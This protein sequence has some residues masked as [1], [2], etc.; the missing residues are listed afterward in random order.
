MTRNG[1]PP[2]MAD[3]AELVGVSHQTASRVVN[4]KGRVSPR[5]PRPGLASCTPLPR[6]GCGHICASYASRCALDGRVRS[7]EA[8]FRI[9]ACLVR[10]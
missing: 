10:G 5:T 8:L 3:V 4:G 2:S 9:R 7:W 6:L 1:R